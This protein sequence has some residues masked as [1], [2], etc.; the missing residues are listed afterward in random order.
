VDEKSEGD[1]E[2]AAHGKSEGFRI[3]GLNESPQ[4]RLT[5][6]GELDDDGQ[7]L[8]CLQIEVWS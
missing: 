4:P 5:A 8:V 3:G 7:A 2:L 6:V 1:A